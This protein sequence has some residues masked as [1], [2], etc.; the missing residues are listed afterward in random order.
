MS[1]LI[2]MFCQGIWVECDLILY[3]WMIFNEMWL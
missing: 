2:I 1:V 3:F